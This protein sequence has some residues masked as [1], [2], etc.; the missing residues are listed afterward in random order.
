MTEGLLRTRLE[1]VARRRRQVL[2]WRH[3]AIGWTAATALALGVYLVQRLVGWASVLTLPLVM[4]LGMVTAAAFAVRGSRNEE[5]EYRDAAAEVEKGH[6]ELNGLLLTAVQQRGSAKAPLGYLQRVVLR[7]AVAHSRQHVWPAVIPRW[8][9][10]SVHLANLAA[11][12]LFVCSLWTLRTPGNPLRSPLVMR[13]SGMSVTPGDV[14]LERGQSLV[15]LARFGGSPP[16]SAELVLGDTP[17]TERRIPLTRNLSDPVFGG[18]VPE[19]A[20]PFTYRVEYDGRRS[21][22]YKVTVFEYPRLERADAEL[23]YPGYTRLPARRVEDTHRVTAVEGTRLDLSLQ[24]NKPVRSAQLIPRASA[25][26]PLQLAVV[27]N[28][29]GAALANFTLAEKA[30]YDLVLTDEDGRT[31]KVPAQFFF[32]VLPNR[33]PELKLAS[34]RG[35]L[36]PSALEEIHFEGTVWDDFGVVAHGI[37]LSLVGSE[38]RIVELGRDVPASERHPF[39]YL[40]RLEDLHVQPDQLISWYVWADDI[41]PDGKVRRT[42]GDL[43][44]G[45]IRPFEEVFR[46]GNQENQEQESGGEG[47][48]GGPTQ[49][50]VRLQKQ[51]VSAT[52]KLQR[53][54][55]TPT[56]PYKKDVEV[57]RESQSQAIEQAQAAE[58]NGNGSQSRALMEAVVEDMGRALVRLKDAGESVAALGPALE[59]EQAAY[60]GLLKLQAHETEVTRSRRGRGQGQGGEMANQ[61][62]LDQLELSQDE[63]RYETQRE[64]QAP[65]TPERREQLQVLNRLQELARRQEDLNARLK[66]LQTAL[67]EAKTEQER[68][69]LRRQLKRLEDEQRQM[70]ADLDE[71]NQRTQRPENQ[72]RMSELRRQLEQTREDMRRASDATDDG[73]VSQALAAGT[74]AQRQLETMRDDLRRQNSSQF[75]EDLREMRTAAREL[76]RQQ[77]EISHDLAGERPTDHPTLDSPDRPTQLLDRLAEQKKRWTNLVD[78]ATQVSQAAESAEPLVANH[79]YDTLRQLNQE[80]GRAI[81]Q[82]QQEL[83]DQGQMTRNLYDQLK[84]LADNGNAKSLEATS[85]MLRQGNQT[86]AAEA[87]AH[88]QTNV[89]LMRRGVERAAESVLGDDTAALQFARDELQ[90]LTDQLNREMNTAAGG[91]PGTADPSARKPGSAQ[92]QATGENANQNRS[93]G[94]GNQ[95]A[96]Q[97]QASANPSSEQP[98]AGQTP[99]EQGREGQGQANAGSQAQQGQQEGQDQGQGRQGQGQRGQPGAAQANATGEQQPPGENGDQAQG[100]QQAQTQGQGRGQGGGQGRGERATAQNQPQ[101]GNGQNARSAD[102]EGQPGQQAGA[103]PAGGRG[104]RQRRPADRGPAGLDIEQLVGDGGTG[105]SERGAGP[106]TTE[107]FGP[108]SDRLREVEELVDMPELRDQVATARERARLERQTIRREKKK[109]DWAVVRL[110][111]LK[112]L[113]EVRQAL[114][115][116]LSRR[117][118]DNPL[119]PIDRD[120]VPTRFSELVR[121][122][123]EELGKDR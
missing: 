119:V 118:A 105:G 58:E 74:R 91:Q 17:A 92:D 51:I 75:A 100:Q 29:A 68:N 52:W 73:Q 123:Y 23:T 114:D 84:E 76:E 25:Q 115:E 55:R 108:W 63:N 72:A 41:G 21:P 69:E 112:P 95:D 81:Q 104:G 12:S 10:T 39:Q 67:Q 13:T 113:V 33:V 14:Q 26:S 85:E 7:D 15:V 48:Q 122:Y 24:L 66:E 59:A 57:V 98:G 46:Q 19:V 20:E 22:D 65:N 120:P 77:Q 31:N 83:I 35:D 96:Q 53:D 94:A 90:N 56:E 18:T 45:E 102:A 6:P 117:A 38:P 5:P 80:E 27:T 111:V 70:L 43:Y 9:L 110:E 101:P 32:E 109:P 54:T 34:P 93:P 40:L 16:A 79:L 71:L 97:A 30:A 78:R 50:L 37:G 3:L 8:R 28:R 4:L 87:G 47:G 1:P 44:F 89:V 86:A 60:Q 82:L 116:E 107:A 62:Q 103:N 61:R 36:R 106:I 49:Q 121:R 11:F 88:A 2:F 64:A 99:G 42:T